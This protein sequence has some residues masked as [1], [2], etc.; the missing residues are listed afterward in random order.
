[1]EGIAQ[2]VIEGSIRATGII[3]LKVATLGRYRARDAARLFE[4][5]VG[6]AVIAALLWLVSRYV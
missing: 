2:G 3:V 1:M 5:A 4:G 6:L